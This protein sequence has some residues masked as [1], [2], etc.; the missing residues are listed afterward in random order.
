MLTHSRRQF[1]VGQGCFHAA[2]VGRGHAKRFDPR[3]ILY[4][5]DCGALTPFDSHLSQ[6][7]ERFHGLAGPRR[8]D[9]LFLSHLHADHVSGV[10]RL[11]AA[12]WADVGT[13]VLPL[14]NDV[15]RL[16]SFARTLEEDASGASEFFQDMVVDPVA[17]IAQRLRPEQIIL[18]R[19]GEGPSP[20][21]SEDG[22]PVEPVGP[23]VPRDPGS[24][25]RGDRQVKWRLVGS[26]ESHEN[27]PRGSGSDGGP[28]PRVFTVD[29][30][31]AFEIADASGS[32][33]WVLA[34]YVDTDVSDARVRF[35]AAAANNLGIKIPTFEDWARDPSKLLFL[36]TQCRDELAAAYKAVAGLNVTS[37]SLLSAPYDVAA[38][39]RWRVLLPPPAWRFFSFL[40]SSQRLARHRR[41]R[42]EEGGAMSSSPRALSPQNGAVSLTLTYLHF[43]A[44]KAVVG[45]GFSAFNQL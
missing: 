43:E 38:I 15:D 11:C 33:A 18:V 7:V 36:V 34:P 39:G 9:F 23:S 1:A 22:E 40:P 17:A 19:R 29:D 27:T 5:Y 21:A 35:I 12:V 26:G 8:I 20:G 32:A 2:T 4:V 10:E 41:R 44:A 16:I 25:D 37:L 13:V 30:T 14:L 3:G 28:A 31:F 42:S 6:A 45:Q 24:G